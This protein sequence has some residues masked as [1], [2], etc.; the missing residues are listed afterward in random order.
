MSKS[1]GIDAAFF[2]ELKGQVTV[3]GAG[4]KRCQRINGKFDLD[5]KHNGRN[6]YKHVSGTGIIFFDQFW[7][8]SCDN[9]VDSF[10]Y[11]NV[12]E[13]EAEL[14]PENTWAAREPEFEPAPTVVDEW[15]QRLNCVK[16]FRRLS[17]EKLAMH[18]K[19]VIEMLKDAKDLVRL[20]A[21]I[22]LG[23]LDNQEL[24]HVADTIT[25]LIREEPK[26]SVREAAIKVLGQLRPEELAIHAE[27]ISSVLCDVSSFVRLWALIALAKLNVEELGKYESNI[28]KV[29]QS[30]AFLPCA[31]KAG[32]MLKE[33]R[34]KSG[35]VKPGDAA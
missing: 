13:L 14:M 3:K 35:K 20:E 24:E 12:T 34:Y 21:V 7:K 22:A 5:G 11:K 4:G 15:L 28:E 6:K 9:D 31:E 10:E 33:Y 30:D 8:I 29:K 26:E 25:E 17:P 16:V 23:G 27:Q 1:D 32:Q 19:S 2:E 18:V